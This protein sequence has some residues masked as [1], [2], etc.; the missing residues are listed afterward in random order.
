[1]MFFYIIQF[2]K[3]ISTNNTKIGI[4]CVFS[5]FIS[6]DFNEEEPDYFGSLLDDTEK[7]EFIKKKIIQEI[8]F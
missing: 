4:T 8:C 2:I 1:M 6:E 7:D 3:K 5:D